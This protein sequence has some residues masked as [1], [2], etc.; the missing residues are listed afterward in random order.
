MKNSSFFLSDLLTLNQPLLFNLVY[1][2]SCLTSYL[3]SLQVYIQEFSMR[4]RRLLGSPSTQKKKRR[5]YSIF[6][7]TTAVV[8]VV[9]FFYSKQHK[10]LRKILYPTICNT[11]KTDFWSHRPLYGLGPTH[12]II[13]YVYI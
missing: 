4:M 2:A 13:L 3:C 1:K 9:L 7:K 11:P 6:K 10:N 5:G 8:S 12:I